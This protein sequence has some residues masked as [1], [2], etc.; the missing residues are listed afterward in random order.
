MQGQ[1]RPLELDFVAS[2]GVT[3]PAPSSVLGLKPL[4]YRVYAAP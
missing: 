3:T 1:S 4:R 2:P